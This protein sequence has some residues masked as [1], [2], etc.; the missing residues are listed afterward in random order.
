MVLKRKQSC[1]LMLLLIGIQVF[2]F[3]Q[4]S[5]DSGPQQNPASDQLVSHSIRQEV[6]HLPENVLD[7]QKHIWTSPLRLRLKDAE[8]LTPLV[9][10]TTGLIMTD[11]AA[12]Y[13]ATRGSHQ[14]ISNDFSNA[15]LGMLGLTAGSMYITGIRTGNDHVRETG[16]LS[17]EAGVDALGVDE[18]LKFAFSRQR[19]SEGA[20]AGKF[21]QSDGSSFPSAHATT[22]FAVATVMANE[23]PGP[24]T[25]LL[26]YG[27]ATAIS[28]ARVG[29]RQHFPSDV[30][31]GAAMGYLIGRGVEKRH[32][33]P[34]IDRFGAFESEAPPLSLDSMSSS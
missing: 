29:A 24:I 28:F 8:W 2:A 10:I 32:H 9:G 34:T 4:T 16:V 18:A 15:G 33:D 27:T 22:A 31:V 14:Q 1:L 17:M 25:K 7:D 19:P 12:S 6:K 26:A 23:Y 21:F 20:G 11:R 3:G 30:F 5:A 13:E